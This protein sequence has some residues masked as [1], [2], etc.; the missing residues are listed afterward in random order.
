MHTHRTFR[1]KGQGPFSP[2]TRELVQ[3][4]PIGKSQKLTQD[5]CTCGKGAAAS[6]NGFISTSEARSGF[7]CHATTHATKLC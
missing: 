4:E 2:G 6:P 5:V 3:E 1:R 7:R